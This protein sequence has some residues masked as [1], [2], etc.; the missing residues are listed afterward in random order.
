MFYGA[1]GAGIGDVD[2]MT[3]A[4]NKTGNY[5]KAGGAYHSGTTASVQED[6]TVTAVGGENGSKVQGVIWAVKAAS[7]DDVKALGGNEITNDSNVLT[8]TMGRGQTNVNTMR[9]YEALVEAP[10]YSYYILDHAPESYLALNGNEFSQGNVSAVKKD[11]IEAEVVYG[12]RWGDVQLDMSSATDAAEYIVNGVVITAE[13]GT[14]KG[15]YHLGQIWSSSEI[16]WKASETPDL[17]GKTITNVRYYVSVKD[18]DLGD[19]TVP[20]YENK[21]LDYPINLQV[22]KVF[23]E[24]ISAKFITANTIAVAGIPAD[25]TNVA[26]RVYYSAGR[27]SQPQYLTPLSV[28]PESDAFVP[29]TAAMVGGRISIHPGSATNK[30]GETRE[31]GTPAQEINYTVEVTSD[32][33]AFNKPTAA[34]VEKTKEFSGYVLMNIPYDQFYE[35]GSAKI[36]DVDAMAGATNKTGNYGKAGGAY[37]NGATASVQ[38][39]GTVTAVGGENGSKVQGVIWAVKAA[40]LDE[41]KALG[42][43][44]ITDDSMAVTA[45]QAHGSTTS[46]TLAGYEALSEAPAY[47]YYILE[48]E[49][50]NFLELKD[51]KFVTGKTTEEPTTNISVNVAYGTHW[52]DIQLDLSA[53]SEVSNLLINGIELKADDG[54]IVG[55]YHLD[56]IAWKV[57]TTPGLDGKKLVNVRYYASIKDDNLGDGEAPEYVNHVYDYA[58]DLDLA[59]VYTGSVTA[60]FVDEKTIHVTGLPVDVVN[61]KAKVY[62][63]QGRGKDAVTT[64]LT[65]FENNAETGEVIASYVDIV[66]GNIALVPGTPQDGTTYTVEIISENYAI[67]STTVNYVAQEG[68]KEPDGVDVSK[69]EALLKLAESVK[70]EEYTDATCKTLKEEIEKAK[71]ALA[72][73]ELQQE[74]I[75]ALTKSLQ[76]AIDALEKKP[77][78]S[79][80][81]EKKDDPGKPTP[82]TSDQGIMLWGVLFVLAAVGS[83]SIYKFKSGR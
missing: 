13:D 3:G 2:I 79:P 59:K 68:E 82:T 81:P 15:L 52:G 5:G 45:T 74:E 63:T 30:E 14:S 73:P 76:A 67:R 11:A 58:V 65:Q 1:N 24:E 60:E 62:F 53:A 18:N 6:G 8:A 10:A 26:A 17:D 20:A 71:E 9:G 48:Q 46:N 38:E 50:A 35:T 4:T 12:S 69:L 57:D 27:G 44:E 16:A 49:P 51:K 21:V 66:D 70:T 25:A 7:L 28:D 47:S 29:E 42:G 78:E 31:Y 72:R 37:H 32:N 41:V 56:Q 34:Y 22:K 33:Y 55:L 43:S 83:A 54:T 75:D 64:Y 80:A 61:A 19:E 23:G 40:S 77:N 39:D 36:G